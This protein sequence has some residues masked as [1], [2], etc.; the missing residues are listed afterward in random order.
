M[1][2]ES[3]RRYTFNRSLQWLLL[4]T[5]LIGSVTLQGCSGPNINLGDGDLPPDY[6]PPVPR[7]DVFVN[8]GEHPFCTN[9]K[10]ASNDF[11]H[12]DGVYRADYYDVAKESFIYSWMA[13]N[14]YE[15]YGGKKPEY[16]FESWKRVGNKVSTWRGMGAHVYLSDDLDRVVIAY[17]G[18]NSSSIGDWL[19]GNFN[20]FWKGQYGEALKLA[21]NVVERYPD[22][23]LVTT[24]HSLGGGLA[25]H[26]ALHI[27]DTVAYAF[28]SSPRVFAPR[29]RNNPDSRLV[30]VSENVDVLRKI[31]SAWKTL[32]TYDQYDEFDFLNS[33][34][35]TEHSIYYIGRGL[36]N[37]AASTGEPKYVKIAQ[38]L[39]KDDKGNPRNPQQ[40]PV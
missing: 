6:I 29:R 40:C 33:D 39:L 9:I 16:E 18:T 14:A 10:F 28:N 19:F 23:K 7:K 21:K 20:I 34:K 3:E 24:G 12:Y 13:S 8:Y 35:I 11:D 31:R 26:V 15:D 36:A 17:E 22:A 5:L 4:L 27:N 1:K 2:N 37:V 30:I 38:A 32:D 25:I